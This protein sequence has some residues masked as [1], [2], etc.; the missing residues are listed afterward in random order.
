MVDGVP[1]KGEAV[2]VSVCDKP[3][4]HTFDANTVMVPPVDPAMAVMVLPDEE[5]LHP[6]GNVQL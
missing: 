2:T 4:P 6:A 3:A 5:P 1:G